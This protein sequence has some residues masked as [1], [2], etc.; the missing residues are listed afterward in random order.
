MSYLAPRGHG[1]SSY[2]TLDMPVGGPTSTGAELP[3]RSGSLRASRR[4]H[5]ADPRRAVERKEE[6]IY[7][8]HR[9]PLPLSSCRFY[10][11]GMM[12]SLP[13]PRH[14]ANRCDVNWPLIGLKGFRNER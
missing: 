4:S 14:R 8:R 13:T 9:A 6:R 3:G 10:A 7:H 5:T 2:R 11:P 1:G 12:P